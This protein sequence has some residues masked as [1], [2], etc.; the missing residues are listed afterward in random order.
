M[1]RNSEASRWTTMTAALNIP[2]MIPGR[3]SNPGRPKRAPETGAG[4]SA[5][6][7][8]GLGR[9]SHLLLGVLGEHRP[10]LQREVT[11]GKLTCVVRQEL[12]FVLLALRELSSRTARMES[13]AR[14]RVDR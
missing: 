13:A 6:L 4:A 10:I 11:G 3:R 5:R 12:R 9:L 14:G 1:I 2:S 7:R 8:L